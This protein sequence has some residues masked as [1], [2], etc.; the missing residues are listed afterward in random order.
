MKLFAVSFQLPDVD[1]LTKWLLPMTVRLS[2]G[3]R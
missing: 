2:V 1:R 3:L